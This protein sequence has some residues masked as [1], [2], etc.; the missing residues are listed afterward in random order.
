MA[1]AYYDFDNDPALR[2]AVLVGHGEHF[3]RGNVCYSA[4]DVRGLRADT[5]RLSE[6][7]DDLVPTECWGDRSQNCFHD[8][9]VVG[10]AQLIRNR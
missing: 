6:C 4:S 10:N 5:P 8:M 9:R 7:G 2:A 3:S 1:K